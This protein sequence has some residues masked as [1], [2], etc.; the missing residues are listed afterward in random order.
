[1]FR[2]GGTSKWGQRVQLSTGSRLHSRAQTKSMN[3]ELQTLLPLR[4][5]CAGSQPWVGA[6]PE[7]VD[8]K[9]NMTRTI[10]TAS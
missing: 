3:C 8:V 10:T 6:R 9:V 7:E 1:M 4:S 2:K 5:K